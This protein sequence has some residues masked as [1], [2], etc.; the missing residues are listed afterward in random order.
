[1]EFKCGDSELVKSSNTFNERR[2]ALCVFASKQSIV[3]P[4]SFCDQM[5]IESTVRE[6]EVVGKC[7]YR[8]VQTWGKV[9]ISNL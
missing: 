4:M 3:L 8:L 2:E 7:Q 1:M 5:E 9:R 6:C